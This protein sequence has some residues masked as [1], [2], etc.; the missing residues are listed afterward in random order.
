MSDYVSFLI[1]FRCS[2]KLLIF[3]MISNSYKINIRQTQKNTQIETIQ[4]GKQ[5]YLLSRVI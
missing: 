5:I 4:T 2:Q 3:R 1:T